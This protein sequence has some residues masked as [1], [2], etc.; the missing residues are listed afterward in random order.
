MEDLELYYGNGYLY[1]GQTVGNPAFS[2]NRQAFTKE[3]DIIDSKT[4]KFSETIGHVGES[5]MG[6]FMGIG[7]SDFRLFYGMTFK[8]TRERA[9]EIVNIHN[10]EIEP[11]PWSSSF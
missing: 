10:I 3:M 11:V 5:F 6:D 1:V 9:E 7:E 8:I 4:N 2:T